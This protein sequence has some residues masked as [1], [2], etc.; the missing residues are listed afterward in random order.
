MKKMKKFLAL[1]I[2]MAM[3]LGM[4]MTVFATSGTDGVSPATVTPNG[5]GSI[6]I[7]N[8]VKGEKYTVYRL[9]NAMAN[10]TTGAIVYG[11]APA[12]D[13]GAYFELDD[14]GYV[15][16]K[17]TTTDESVAEEAFKTWAKS[18]GEKVEEI[19]AS[20]NGEILFM[21]LTYGYY[22]VEST[23]GALISVDSL[24][25]NAE[26]T[27]KN[28]SNPEV[29][30]DAKKIVLADGTTADTTSAAIGEDV[31]FEISFDARNYDGETLIESYTITDTP[32]DL[33]IKTNTVVVK[34][35][36]NPTATDDTHVENTITGLTG[37]T[38]SGLNITIPWV[39]VNGDNK[40]SKYA[41]KSQI[42]ITY[43]ATVISTA[44][45]GEASNSASI[46]W[47]GKDSP[48][49]PEP[50]TVKTYSFTLQKVDGKD[51]NTQLEGAKFKLY[52]G[53]TEI[54]VVAI[55]A[56]GRIITDIDD[57]DVT[58]D[59]YR[60]ATA[61]EQE[62][63]VEIKAGL[64]TIKG[65][66]EGQEYQLE[67]TLAP[68][69]YNKVGEKSEAFTVNEDSSAEGIDVTIK[70]NQGAE[71]PSTGG[72]GTTIFYIVGGILVVGA[73]VVLITRRRMDVQ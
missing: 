6:T 10:A 61:E 16:A 52:S 46:T 58:I 65:L 24:N 59:H 5:T 1:L 62:S 23:Q 41:N 54:K 56:E 67:E 42:V 60:V 4:G 37:I 50:P 57:D 12:D 19:T 40:E 55:D 9:F 66:K 73:G 39:N 51:T 36:E 20:E 72:I 30:D 32:S 47:T 11:Q 45:D 68:K 33:S 8:A 44:E 28:S 34:V 21:N 43:T 49:E 38:A 3:V 27:D 31:N 2:A 63:A 64:I 69:G 14:E 29:S 15:V 18:K 26:M 13:L 17:S 70:N 53:E 48:D 25:P 71:L 22:F 7:T 35:I